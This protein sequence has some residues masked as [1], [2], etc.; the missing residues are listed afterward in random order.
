MLFT[1]Y[2]LLLVSIIISDTFVYY[3]ALVTVDELCGSKM[4]SEAKFSLKVSISSRARRRPLWEAE[5]RYTTGMMTLTFQDWETILVYA[6]K[7]R[8]QQL[9]EYLTYTENE[10]SILFYLNA[11][12]THSIKEGTTLN[13]TKIFHSILK[14]HAKKIVVA[15]YM[16]DYHYD[17]IKARY[18]S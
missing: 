9:L 12:V 18:S 8:N 10:N 5:V 4:R 14:K 11:T 7:T 3:L 6:N 13:M 15:D 2:L 1:Y 17:E 16:I